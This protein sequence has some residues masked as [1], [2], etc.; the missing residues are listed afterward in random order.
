MVAKT[1]SLITQRVL[2][3]IRWIGP[4]AA[5][6]VIYNL[7]AEPSHHSHV[8]SVSGKSAEPPAALC[9]LWLY[10]LSATP[11]LK[12]NLNW[13]PCIIMQSGRQGGNAFC[14]LWQNK[15]MSAAFPAFFLVSIVI[16]L[17]VARWKCISSKFSLTMFLLPSN[18][19]GFKG[20]VCNTC[21]AR[22]ILFKMTANGQ[23]SFTDWNS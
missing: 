23:S 14:V 13:L 16:C 4:Q 9:A 15:L 7:R 2:E 6:E 5:R 22:Y 21:S 3:T 18:S 19:I 12:Y 10:R 8:E 1:L 17:A 11:Q 20:T